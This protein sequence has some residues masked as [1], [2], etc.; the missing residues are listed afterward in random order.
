M[1]GGRSA[2][3]Q[4]EYMQ[5]HG[6]ALPV[7]D[8]EGGSASAANGHDTPSTASGGK[9]LSIFGGTSEDIQGDTCYENKS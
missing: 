3:N 7:V 4:I 2:A 1:A 9:D 5:K 8:D 6:S